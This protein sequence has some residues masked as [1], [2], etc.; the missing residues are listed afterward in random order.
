MEQF[1]LGLSIGL[2]LTVMAGPITLTIIE[3]SVEGGRRAGL[4]AAFG[5]WTSDIAFITLALISGD[6][7]L[8]QMSI[9]AEAPWLYI[10]GGLILIGF[11]IALW[12]TRKRGVELTTQDVPFRSTIGHFFRGIAINSFNPFSVVFWSTITLTMV[13]G[14]ELSRSSTIAFYVGIMSMLMIGDSLKVFLATW[15]RALL[16]S[17]GIRTVR[18]VVSVLF[19]LLGVIMIG[20]LFY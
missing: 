9:R 1:L 18:S 5:T 12:M 4:A 15:M 20:R 11:G 13:L 17:K 2:G 14:P 16:S 10:I 19:M 6:A 3:S 8:S 7:L